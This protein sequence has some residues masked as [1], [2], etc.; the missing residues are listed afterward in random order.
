MR[1]PLDPRR[2]YTLVELLLV[3][4][5]IGVVSSFSI[6]AYQDY[7][8]RAKLSEVFSLVTNPQQATSRYFAYRGE[9]PIDNKSAG[10]APPEQLGGRYV[11]RIEIQNG[12]IHAKLAAIGTYVTA[13]QVVSFRPAT[14][15]VDAPTHSVTWLCGHA[16]PALGMTVIGQNQTNVDRRFLPASCW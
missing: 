14:T 15:L 10:L 16:E 1:R 11:T 3:L 8:V 6:P 5:I 4:L 2:G 9:F 7:T 12:V 13:G